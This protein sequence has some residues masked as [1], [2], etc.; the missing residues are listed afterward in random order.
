MKQIVP[1]QKRLDFSAVLQKAGQIVSI[2]DAM[3]ALG[4][5]RQKAAKTLSRWTQQGW[6]ARVAPGLYAPIPLDAITTEQVIEDPWVMIPSLFGPC[7]VGGWTAANHWDL[8]EQIFKSLFVFTT[9][10]V[11]KKKRIYHNI[12]FTLKHVDEQ[13]LFGLKT[14]WRGGVSISISDKHRTIID[15][16]D[17]PEAGGGIVHILDCLKAYLKEPDADREILINYAKKNGN[18]AVFKRLGFLADKIGDLELSSLCIKEITKGNAKL[19][20]AIKSPR[21]VKKWNLWIPEKSL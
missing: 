1:S 11:R 12:E 17:T 21:L 10:A 20:P 19:D 16:L 6:L 5:D 3:Q 13:A 15:M 9:H 8:T 14:L 4:L 18:G 7:Y 2:E